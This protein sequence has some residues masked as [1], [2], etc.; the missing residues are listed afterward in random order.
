[1]IVG[2]SYAIRSL[3]DRGG[4]CTPLGRALVMISAMSALAFRWSSRSFASQISVQFLVR[5]DSHGGAAALIERADHAL[6]DIAAAGIRV[7]QKH[8][9]D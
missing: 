6:Q 2:Q 7:V 9:P 8:E 4:V 1:M 3:R 5:L